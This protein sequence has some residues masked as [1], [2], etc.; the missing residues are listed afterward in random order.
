MVA[1]AFWMFTQ[2]P[3]IS[4]MPDSDRG[5]FGRPYGFAEQSGQRH[6]PWL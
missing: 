5:D 3:L 2:D 1:A 4:A 6:R